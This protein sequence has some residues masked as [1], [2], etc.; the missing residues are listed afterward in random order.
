[1]SKFKYESFDKFVIR[2]PL[3]SLNHIQDYFSKEFTT[4]EALKEI[5]KKAIVQEAIYLASPVLFSQM[6]KWLNSELNNNK[7][8]ER[9]K[10]S[11]TKYL[12]R[13]SIRCTPF[14]LFAGYSLGKIGNK[15]S[16]ELNNKDQFYGHLRLDMNY[17][18]A[19]ALDLAKIPQIKNQIKF[20]P[21]SS[22]YK[23]G[24]SL[25]YVEYKYISSRRN[26]FV[27]GVDNTEYLQ[28]VLHA[29]KNGIKTK[30]L[31]SLLVNDEIS[32]KEAQRFID[33]L[34]E[35]Q[36]LLS[37]LEPSVTG[38]EFLNQIINVLKPLKGIDQIINFLQEVNDDI[39]KIRNKPIGISIDHYSKIIEKLSKLETKFDLKYLFQTDLVVSGN[40]LEVSSDIPKDVLK[41]I[42]ILNKLTPT[43]ANDNL[44]Q[45]K[46]AFYERYEE[47]E[48]P[49][50]QVLDIESGIGY[51][52]NNGTG[53]LNPLVDDIILPGD[54][55]KYESTIRWN[56]IQSFL[57]KKYN[58]SMQN[59]L[60]EVEISDADVKDFQVN[61]D[62][63]PLTFNLMAEIIEFNE[64]NQ[65]PVMC[66]STAGGSSAANLLGRFC[67]SD[68]DLYNY[69]KEIT[70]TERKLLSDAII[71]DIIH[72]PE[73]R[74]GNI[75]S[76]PQLRDYEINYLAKSSV[77][78]EN[79]VAVE[80]LMISV[81][82]GKRIVLRSKSLN[83]EVIPR[84][85]NAHNFSNN[86]LPVYQF[87]CDLQTQDLRGGIGFNWGILSNEYKYLPRVK[88]K[89]VILSKATWNMK[90]EDIKNI[91]DAKNDIE[92]LQKAKLWRDEFKL[93]DYVLLADGDNELLL[94]LGNST[95]LKIMLTLVKRLPKF[96][97]KEFLFKPK[98]CIVRREK[99]RFTN[100]LVFSFYK[101]R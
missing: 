97:L 35:S 8:I 13:M 65:K 85:S 77:S 5:C 61:W 53:D 52:Q 23:S 82:F 92:L 91:V 88:Y 57:L 6:C 78:K 43:R 4:D 3:L 63:L 83:K 33:E 71:A 12:L 30:D 42:E 11:I 15:T 90:K 99:E 86:T 19:L 18:C 48:V 54:T 10:V 44:S 60:G 56:N 50:L 2:T 17:L 39:N 37:E 100:Q 59:G 47:K 67:H 24:N 49:L 64:C 32:I 55:G 75:L 89:N 26:H 40:D 16:I 14:G 66:F 51:L 81:K 46:K 68:T 28:K 80:D 34:I 25:R 95:C 70:E 84:L 93:P 87:L 73:S 72:L 94:N 45:F 69:V 27:V 58:E 62:D 79:R 38:E 7:D 41:G 20:Y 98:N 22:L 21:N 101:T 31:V 1:M 74:T 76:R 96:K 29:S 36:L 9:I